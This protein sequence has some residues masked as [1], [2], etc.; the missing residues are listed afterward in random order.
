[1][2]FAEGLTQYEAYSKMQ[3]EHLRIYGQPCT[4]MVPDKNISV[5]Y[6]NVSGTEFSVNYEQHFMTCWIEWAVPRSVLYRFNYFPDEQE[7]LTLGFFSE[8]DLVL[9]D[10]FIRT[11]QI[12]NLSIWGDIYLRV[13]KIQDEGKF[14]SLKRLWFMR[15]MPAQ[16]VHEFVTRVTA[17]AVTLP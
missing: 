14:K 15:V 13:V 4:V 3:L 5:G 16:D 8:P 17:P 12:E 10:S 2:G 7:D 9:E 6:E 11:A 1:M